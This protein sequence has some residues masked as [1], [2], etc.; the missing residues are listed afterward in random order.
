MPDRRLPGKLH[1][2]GMLFEHF[3][4]PIRHGRFAPE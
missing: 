2:C 3:A 1:F 4:S